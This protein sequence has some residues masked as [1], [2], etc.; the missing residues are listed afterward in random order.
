M[1]QL[2]TARTAGILYLVTI[3]TA[4]FA[5]AL[6]RGKLVVRTDAAATATNIL[7][8]ESLYRAGGVADVLNFVCYTIVI[9]LFFLLF[10]SVNKTVAIVSVLS[11]LIGCAAGAAVC[12]FHFVALYVLTGVQ[13]TSVFSVPQVQ[14]LAL[15]MLRLQSTSY[16]VGTVFFGCYCGLIGYLVFRSTFLP[17]VLGVLMLIAGSGY[18]IGI[19]ARFLSPTVAAYLFPYILLP[20]FIAELSLT[21]WL[22]VRAVNSERW[23]EA[24][25]A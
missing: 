6:V 21:L 3:V 14:A 10:R 11:G 24:A 12:V 20:G 19:I 2:I 7:T 9:G 1:N 16:S 22:I 18:L 15:L 5:E 8:H 4:G 13:Y 25:S 23:T 17:R